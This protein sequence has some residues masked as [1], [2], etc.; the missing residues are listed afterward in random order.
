[1][2][3]INFSSTAA[4]YTSS[5]QLDCKRISEYSNVIYFLLL[6]SDIDVHC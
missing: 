4:A 1:M 3:L 6:W 2:I 5:L